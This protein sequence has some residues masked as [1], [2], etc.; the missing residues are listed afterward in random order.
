MRSLAAEPIIVTTCRVLVPSY[1]HP[2]RWEGHAS[3][4]EEMA[5]QLPQTG[6]QPVKPDAIFCSVGGG[7]LLG[8]IIEGCN[9]VG[10]ENG[11]SSDGRF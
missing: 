6:S 8:G 5:K 3:M 1:D 2:T 10:W 4:V 7:G 9:R 11:A